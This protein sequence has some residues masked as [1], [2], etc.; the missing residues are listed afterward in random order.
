MIIRK[1]SHYDSSFFSAIPQRVENPIEYYQSINSL[2]ALIKQDFPLLNIVC[3]PAALP[4]TAFIQGLLLPKYAIQEMYL[5]PEQYYEYGLP[6]FAH[7]PEKFQ[8]VG[9]EVYDSCKRINW[10]EIPY[11]FLHCHSQNNLELEHGY[12]KICTH[13]PEY[14]T[15]DNCVINVLFSA[16]YLFQ[17]YCRYDATKKF[18]LKCLPHGD[19]FNTGDSQWKTKN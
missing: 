5:L 9:I 17:E 6:I 16:F 18:K 11:E 4:Q 12:R 8:S 19:K 1:A 2:F 13:K 15:P 7:I 3:L 10:S 14:I